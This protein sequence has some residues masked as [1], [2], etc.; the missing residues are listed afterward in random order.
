MKYGVYFCTSHFPQEREVWILTPENIYHGAGLIFR[1]YHKMLC[2][3]PKDRRHKYRDLSDFSYEFLKHDAR[4]ISSEPRI[5]K[6]FMWALDNRFFNSIFAER[7][8]L[9]GNI[10][11]IINIVKTGW[12]LYHKGIPN[13][14][15]MQE[16]YEFNDFLYGLDQENVRRGGRSCW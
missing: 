12:R 5:T 2:H 7:V 6:M 11:N 8:R 9:D 3:C 14:R 15:G 4:L 13:W 16:N 10:K 1:G